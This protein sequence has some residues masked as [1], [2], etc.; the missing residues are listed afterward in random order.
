MLMLKIFLF[1]NSLGNLL[2][3]T[4]IKMSFSYRLFIVISYKMIAGGI[5]DLKDEK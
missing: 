2:T 5:Y 1:F 3:K 4:Y